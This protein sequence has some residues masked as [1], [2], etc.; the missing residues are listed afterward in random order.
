MNMLC[1]LMKLVWTFWVIG[2]GVELSFTFAFERIIDTAKY[3]LRMSQGNKT[4][5]HYE[6]DP[7]NLWLW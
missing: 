1:V 6:H 5:N 4:E 2:A 3:R 7:H